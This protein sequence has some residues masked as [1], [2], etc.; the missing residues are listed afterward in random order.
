MIVLSIICCATTERSMDD[1]DDLLSMG[2]RY[3]LKR[4]FTRQD[5]VST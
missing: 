2:P 5:M 3:R 4:G 1:N